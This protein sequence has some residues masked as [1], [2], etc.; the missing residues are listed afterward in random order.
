MHT[1]EKLLKH[2]TQTLNPHVN[3]A[4]NE[5][6]T[7]LQHASGKRKEH[8][9]AH[10]E[11]TTDHDTQHA[12]QAQINRRIKGE[13]LAYIL[14]QKE[15]WSLPLQV[16]PEVLIPRPETELLVEV[17]LNCL[18]SQ[19][20]AT[21]LD[22]GTGS[23][24]IALA[25]AHEQVDATII[26]SDISQQCIDIATRNAKQLN[27]SNVSFVCGDWFEAAPQ[28]KFNLIV[29]NPPYIA[30]E[31]SHIEEHVRT[32]EPNIALF[33]EDNGMQ[34]LTHIIQHAHNKLHPAGQ[35]ILEHGWQQADS[36]NEQLEKHGYQT[37]RNHR[38]L[39]GHTRVTS[40]TF[41][42]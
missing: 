38:D 17:A 22:L 31:D 34:A 6:L 21:I 32:Y 5:A 40:A 8:I 42:K 25:L 30:K 4:Y 7:L 9:L 37:I 33:S 23:G 15:F 24:C 28:E 12:Y 16:G 20:Q 39:Q 10:A 19:A 13:P 35:L 18:A 29:S 2:G 1:F 3:N 27:I 14:K 26:A 36:V 41:I 11:D